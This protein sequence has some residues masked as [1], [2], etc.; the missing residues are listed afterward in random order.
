MYYVERIVLSFSVNFDIYKFT[1]LHVRTFV[2]L[3]A[4]SLTKPP[5]NVL[6]E[7]ITVHKD[8]NI[9][10]SAHFLSLLERESVLKLRYCCLCVL[11]AC[12]LSL[13]VIV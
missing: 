8:N 4:R 2:V 6:H 3:S 13:S 9:S 11:L 7:I 12:T 5:I 10:A 1:H